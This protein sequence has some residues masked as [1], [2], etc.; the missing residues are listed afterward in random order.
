MATLVLGSDAL[1][2]N[3]LFGCPFSMV[4]AQV[5]LLELGK[6]E[7]HLPGLH[8]SLPLPTK[9]PQLGNGNPPL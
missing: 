4:R 7:T 9:A 3:S 6:E 2:S 8:H 1:P 5:I